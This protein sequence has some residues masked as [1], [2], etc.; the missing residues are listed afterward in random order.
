MRVTVQVAKSFKV[1]AKPL[2]KKYPSLKN[3]L[4]N[5][6]KK[7][8]KNPK[9]GTPLGHN[10]YKIR[11]KIGSKGKGKAVVHGLFLL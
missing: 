4:L 2:L 1:A 5:L 7:L 8:T 10:A 6:E 3:D 9:F 11:L